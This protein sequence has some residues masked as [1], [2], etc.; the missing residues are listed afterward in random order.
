MS[1][2]ALLREDVV[3]NLRADQELDGWVLIARLGRGGNGEV[4]CAT[5][6]QHGHA[7]LKVLSQKSGDRWPRFCDEVKIMEKLGGRPG[8]LPLLAAELSS[9]RSRCPAWLATPVAEPMVQALG[10][11]ASLDEVVAAV[12]AI[13]RTL[14]DLAALEIFH[15]DIK[16]DN[17]FRWEHQWVVGDFGLVD[18]PEKAAITTGRRRLGPLYFIAPEM[19]DRPDVAGPGAADVYSLAK[20]LWVLATGQRYPPQGQIRVG[21][22]THNLAEW[23][24]GNGTL[25]LGL[26]LQDATSDVPVQRPTMTQFVEQLKE[27][28]TG[29]PTQ[30]DRAAETLLSSQLSSLGEQLA[31]SIDP[32]A[33]IRIE[34][35]FREVVADAQ[36]RSNDKRQRLMAQWRGESEASR[37]SFI[38]DY[39]IKAAMELHDTPWVGSL[40]DGDDVIYAVRRKKPSE[41]QAELVRARQILWGR[42]L[43]WMHCVGFIAAL[44]LRGGDGCEPLATE[45]AAE[46]VRHH[47]LDFADH[48]T[49]AAAWRLQRSQ[50]PVVARTAGYGP[51]N[52]VAQSQIRASLR[53]GPSE[54][55]AQPRARAHDGR[56]RRHAGVSPR[57]RLVS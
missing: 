45:I 37:R 39:G 57:A 41:R 40:G 34:M 26:L 19:I 16:P 47:L 11:D 12:Q 8:V 31:D 18:Y 46:E 50:I 3:V 56:S 51:L 29:D 42:P 44:K 9:S 27:W 7:A 15:R 28:T 1:R 52:E 54:G 22:P 25:A 13:A 38:D 10:S 23:R 24:D 48:P 35:Q 17:L 49:L 43:W 20:T 4:W 30:D 36:K 5:H 6:P 55:S 14:A 53:R 2:E 21:V 32:N 33:F